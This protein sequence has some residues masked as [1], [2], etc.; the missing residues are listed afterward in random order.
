MRSPFQIVGNNIHRP[1]QINT[2]DLRTLHAVRRSHPAFWPLVP[3]VKAVLARETINFLMI[4]VPAFTSEEHIYLPIAVPYTDRGNITG[5]LAQHTVV[6]N[7]FAI[8]YRAMQADPSQAR[9]VPPGRQDQG[10][11]PNGKCYLFHGKFRSLH[12]QTPP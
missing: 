8:V 3:Q 12:G 4:D 6:F 2:D 9:R 1:A 5:A 11:Q 10:G 7:R